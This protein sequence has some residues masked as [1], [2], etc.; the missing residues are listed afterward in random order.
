MIC[1]YFTDCDCEESPYCIACGCR[2]ER[3]YLD[4]RE[5]DR[6]LYAWME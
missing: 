3:E 6:V 5:A 1:P 4:Q 2:E